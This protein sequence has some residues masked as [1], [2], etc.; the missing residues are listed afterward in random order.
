MLKHEAIKKFQNLYKIKKYSNRM[1]EKKV[2]K[3]KYTEEGIGISGFTL[4]ILS[5]LFAGGAGVVISIVGFFL[6]LYQQKKNPTSLG[7][8]GI[9]LNIIGFIF[10]IIFI[11]ISINYLMPL[12]Q[13]MASFPT[14]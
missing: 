1:V 13:E 4:G 9:I 3:K 14:A 7:K 10:G 2:E 11:I 6:C 12:V 5:L 8:I